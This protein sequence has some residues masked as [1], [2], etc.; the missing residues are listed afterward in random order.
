MEC[1]ETRHGKRILFF[2]LE[3]TWSCGGGLGEVFSEVTT[4][5][6]GQAAFLAQDV[7]HYTAV[8]ALPQ[9]IL[10]T[11]NVLERPAARGWCVPA[12]GRQTTS[13]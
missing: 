10:L 1:P 2:L 5:T 13:P 9:G 12:L 7:P 4:G 11:S 8:P 3:P 6:C